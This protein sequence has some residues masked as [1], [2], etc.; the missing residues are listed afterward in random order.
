MAQRSG[1]RRRAAHEQGALRVFTIL[2][3]VTAIGIGAWLAYSRPSRTASA[4]SSNTEPPTSAPEQVPIAYEAGGSTAQAFEASLSSV[5]PTA[6]VVAED[7]TQWIADARGEDPRRR[8]AA[9]IALSRA[10]KSQAVPVLH[11]VVD[12]GP[13]EPDRQL[14]LRSLHTLAIEQGDADGRIR[15]TMRYAMYH[16]DDEAVAQSAQSFLEDLESVYAEQSTSTS[17]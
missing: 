5:E 7:V 17:R 14:A 15:D 2:I 1:T 11:R 6:N 16:G 13:P 4:E 8:I 10:P 3:A 12:V 9:I